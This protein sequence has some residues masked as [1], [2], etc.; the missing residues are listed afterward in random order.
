MLSIRGERVVITGAAG[1]LGMAMVREF[2]KL[3]AIIEAHDIDEKGLIRLQKELAGFD[4]EIRRCDVS[5]AADFKKYEN[6]ARAAN[7]VPFVWI[8]NAGIALPDA[9]ANLS[10][11]ALARLLAVNVTG[12]M[13]GTRV[14]LR[15][16]AG[17]DRGMIVNMASVAGHIPSPFLA[18]YAASKHAVVGFTRSLRDEYRLMASPIRFILV[19]PGFADT[20]IIKTHHDIVVPSWLLSKPAD[21]ARDI[22]QGILAGREEI[23]SARTGQWFLRLNKYAPALLRVTGR[24]MMA[25]NIKE[26]VGL[27]GISSPGAIPA[28]AASAGT[29]KRR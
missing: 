11:A 19:S 27:C 14:A 18:A 4:I 10:E 24:L 26:L 28:A 13:L 22:V 16:M 29:R 20:D 1:G 15:L 9:F 23:V 17:E 25:K 2:A 3:G 5:S 12:V 7:K 8:N 21:V 6:A